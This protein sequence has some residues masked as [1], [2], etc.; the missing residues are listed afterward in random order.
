MA[1]A[2]SFEL[3]ATLAVACCQKE[4][5][6]TFY[7]LLRCHILKNTTKTNVSDFLSMNPFWYVLVRLWTKSSFKTKQL[8]RLLLSF[9]KTC[10]WS[11]LMPWLGYPAMM[12]IGSHPK[13]T[14]ACVQAA[15]VSKRIASSS[16]QKV[17]EANK[18]VEMRFL[19]AGFIWKNQAAWSS[20]IHQV[21]PWTLHSPTDFRLPNLNHIGRGHLGS[22]IQHQND[23]P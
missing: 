6:G 3:L 17:L 14:K 16:F 20:V 22:C 21:Y 5:D 9:T 19:N 23:G 12:R 13:V 18:V 7:T 15:V 4:L 10:T 8:E 1:S 11:C 2:Y